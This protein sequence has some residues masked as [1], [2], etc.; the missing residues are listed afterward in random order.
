VKARIL[1]IVAWILLM[2]L[3]AA[4]VVWL[5]W[6]VPV[7][8]FIAAFAVAVLLRNSIANVVNG[9]WLRRGTAIRPGHYVRIE[10]QPDVEGYVSHIGGRHTLL[11][12]PAGDVLRLPN[13]TFA[14][15]I[16]TNFHLATEP[17]AILVDVDVHAAVEP[18]R[19]QATIEYEAE[20]LEDSTPG[21]KPGCQVRVL[22]G[23]FPACRRFVVSCRAEVPDHRDMLRHELES[24]I[25]KRLHRE[26]ISTP[27]L[28]PIIQEKP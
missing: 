22:P 9:F 16:F 10:G 18:R 24:R 11:Q 15:S 21:I 13:T 26:G 23:R 20:Q 14:N 12:T 28:S 17:D 6:P 3:S 25:R 7:M 1:V 19:V 27:V 8:V 2:V 5:P 4:L